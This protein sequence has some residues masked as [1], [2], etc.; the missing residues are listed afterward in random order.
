[1][2][3][4]LIYAVNPYGFSHLRRVNEDNIDLNRNFLNF[5]QTLPVNSGY[6]VVHPRFSISTI[7]L[8]ETIRLSD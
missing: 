5:E 1:M 6:A 4:L 7:L 3:L 2:A 8:M